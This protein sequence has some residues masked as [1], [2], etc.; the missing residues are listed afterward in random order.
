MM[1]PF[2]LSPAELVMNAILILRTPDFTLDLITPSGNCIVASAQNMLC[3]W[4][5]MH[6]AQLQ[7]QCMAPGTPAPAPSP[8]ILLQIDGIVSTSA[9]A[10]DW[11]TAGFVIMAIHPL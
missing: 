4:H 8:R 11:T 7:Q 1:P 6:D 10:H 3:T 9:A 5:T 2:A